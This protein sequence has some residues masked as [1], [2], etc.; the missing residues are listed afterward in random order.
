MKRFC[1]G[2][3]DWVTGRPVGE[4]GSNRSH[5]GPSDLTIPCCKYTCTFLS[6]T[7]AA[8]SGS[9]WKPLEAFLEV[10]ANDLACPPASWTASVSS[11][12]Y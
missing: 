7:L 2:I 3:S 8:T 4:S 11:K 12:V 6:A 9:S 5:L 1:S 10:P